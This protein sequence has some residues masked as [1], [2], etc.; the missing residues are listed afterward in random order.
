MRIVIGG[1]GFISPK[2]PGGHPGRGQNNNPLPPFFSIGGHHFRGRSRPLP[3]SLG[4]ARA[5]RVRSFGH[6]RLLPRRV[7]PLPVARRF[8]PATRRRSECRRPAGGESRHFLDIVPPF[9]GRK[10][11]QAQGLAAS[12]RRRS[13]AERQGRP[14][15]VGAEGSA[16]RLQLLRRAGIPDDGKLRPAQGAFP[17]SP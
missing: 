13:T 17:G 2:S 7:V 6:G 12:R 1:A 15:R 8:L 3:V 16:H 10:D 5:R 9:S 14:G 4:V 11:R